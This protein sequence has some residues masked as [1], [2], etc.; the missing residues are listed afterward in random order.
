[1]GR[2]SRCRDTWGEVGSATRRRLQRAV[3]PGW[4]FDFENACRVDGDMYDYVQR[5]LMTQRIMKKNN[6]DSLLFVAFGFFK[7]MTRDMNGTEYLGADSV[8]RG[9]NRSPLKCGIFKAV[10]CTYLIW[11]SRF[12]SFLQC[13][14]GSVTGCWDDEHL[15]L[16][17][18]WRFQV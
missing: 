17:S 16:F 3:K 12:P 8:F 14:Y 15:S 18:Y 1:M 5:V 2:S 7:Q 6:S 9:N 4:S 11:G 13:C 10:N